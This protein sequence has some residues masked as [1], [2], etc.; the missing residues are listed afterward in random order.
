MTGGEGGGRTVRA[1]RTE[2]NRG[3]EDGG[4]V[5]TLEAEVM[6]LME[7]AVLVLMLMLVSDLFLF[8]AHF[9]RRT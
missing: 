7:G 1:R 4:K 9:E 5:T 2:E 6:C 3:E 8:L